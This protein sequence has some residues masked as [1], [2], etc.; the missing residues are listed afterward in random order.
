VI[1]QRPEEL[2]GEWLTGALREAGV[3]AGE[4][5][6]DVVVEPFSDGQ[7]IA[8]QIVRLRL[9]YDR[10]GPGPPA[11]LIAKLPGG[12]ETNR[13]TAEMIGAYE[14][15]I[16]FY[17]ELAHRVEIRTP[18]HVYS[19]MDP[20]PREGSAEGWE[21]LLAWV[22]MPALGFLP[23]LSRWLAGRSTRRYLLLLED[24][25]PARV[26]DQIAGCTAE[27]AALALQSLAGTQAAFWQSPGLDEIPWLR[28]SEAAPR[29]RHA[30]FRRNRRRLLRDYAASPDLDGELAL[31]SLL[32]A[33]EWLDAHGLAVQRRLAGPPR[34]LVHGDYRLDNLFFGPDGDAAS[35]AAVDWAMVQLGRGVADVAF[36]MGC[37][38]EPEISRAAEHDLVRH[39]HATLVERGVRDYA[40]RECWR[41]YQLAKLLFVQT[42]ILSI[43]A[44]EIAGERG[45]QLGET[46]VRRLAALLPQDE[47]DDLLS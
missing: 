30:V 1:P 28:P 7:G 45:A 23:A 17:R 42:M 36:F 18:R 47:L 22:P 31:G 16:L 27:D 40:H 33:I 38:L 3:L 2:T 8:S 5:V 41:D 13:V 43:E 26:G 19:A 35:V 9:S 6:T 14:R 20:N 37:S 32:G 29:V 11:T 12:A 34:T 21:R 25:A 44:L 10:D 46:F 15:E 24:L 4:R 39:Y